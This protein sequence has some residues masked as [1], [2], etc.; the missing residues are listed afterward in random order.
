MKVNE[1]MTKGAATVTPHATLM[2]A[3]RT[4]RTQAVG[5]LPVCRDDLHIVGIIT[6][7]DIVTRGV[8][9]GKDMETE[10]VESYM[11]DSV[12]CV[13]PDSDVKQAAELMS[14]MQVRRLPVVEHG[15]VIGMVSLADFAQ[16]D[17]VDKR[18]NPTFEEITR[19]NT[20][21]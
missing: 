17:K 21:N 5:V 6:D 8:A 16:D 9:Q 11:T 1:I 14:R 10:K 15:C 12:A 3:A 4:M 13:G 20:A 2:D 19:P 18:V 7:R